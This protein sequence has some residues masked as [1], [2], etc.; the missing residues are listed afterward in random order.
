[1]A[2]A[3]SDSQHEAVTGGRTAC[4]RQRITATISDW[5]EC[6]CP[7]AS[8]RRATHA[9]PTV[10]DG[11]CACV[12]Q[13]DQQALSLL[14]QLARREGQAASQHADRR[15]QAGSSWRCRAWR[16]HCAGSGSGV[17]GSS[18]CCCLHCGELRRRLEREAQFVRARRSSHKC[19]P[20]RFCWPAV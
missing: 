18:C 19:R 3:A 7:V 10:S 5:T 12:I 9:A 16:T 2:I 8:N 17:R 14:E 4:L 13:A 11:K 20:E 15:R 1:M 6:G